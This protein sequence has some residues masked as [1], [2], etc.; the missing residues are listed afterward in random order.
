[1]MAPWGMDYGHMSPDQ[2]QHAAMYMYDQVAPGQTRSFDYTFP[3]SV[4]GQRFG[5]GS[6]EWGDQWGGCCD[7]NGMWYAFSVQ[8]HP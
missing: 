2:R 6:Y 1:M 4:V 5:F 3:A 8:P 7:W